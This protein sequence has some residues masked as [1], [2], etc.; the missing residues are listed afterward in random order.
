ML[1]KQLAV[2]LDTDMNLNGNVRIRVNLFP[3]Q[4]SPCFIGDFIPYILPDSERI[5]MFHL[6]HLQQRL[7]FGLDGISHFPLQFA[8][9]GLLFHVQIS[10]IFEQGAFKLD[11]Q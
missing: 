6:H 4:F 10:Y 5:G 9:V 8:L 3:V 7:A 2:I 1:M 11:M